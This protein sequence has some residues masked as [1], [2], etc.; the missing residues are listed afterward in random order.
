MNIIVTGCAGFIGS[1][2]T[3]L[4]SKKH[5]VIG[6]DSLTYASKTENMSNFKDNI[7]FYKTDIVDF[8]SIE[9]IV[10]KHNVDWII[11]FAAETHVDNSIKSSEKFIHSNI[12]GVH[13]LLEVCRVHGCGIF[14]ISTDEVYGSI[15]GGS[16]LETDNLNPKN[17]YSATKASAEHLVT[18][19]VKYK[20]VRMSNNFGPRQ[21]KEKFIPTILNSLKQGKKIPVYGDGKNIR[22]WFYVKDCAK[23][24]LSVFESDIV[25]ETYNLTLVNEK[26]NIK[27]VD[28]IL[29]ILGKN[30]SDCIDYVA[31]RLG[32]DF[33]YSIDNEKF[34][35]NMGEVSATDFTEALQETIKY[36]EKQ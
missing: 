14:Q 13:S 2:F 17:P 28:T 20:M 10:K 21:N 3:D 27:V 33:R 8:R 12:M 11:N 31:D 32:H 30:P 15:Q 7:V 22:D 6:V 29:Q 34:I 19:G 23:C 24:I 26:E 4:L 18:Y 5:S 36:Y 1:H 35:S 9:K 16:F 25:N